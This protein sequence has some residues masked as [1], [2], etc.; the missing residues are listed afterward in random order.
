MTLVCPAH[1]SNCGQLLRPFGAHQH[2]VAN[3]GAA[4]PRY[5]YDDK[6]G[7]GCGTHKNIIL[8]VTIVR[9]VLPHPQ[10]MKAACAIC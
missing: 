7:C 1:I 9:K 3:G 2:S 6:L 10:G 8:E 4:H 5:L